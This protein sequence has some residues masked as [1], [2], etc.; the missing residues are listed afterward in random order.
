MMVEDLSYEKVKLDAIL[1][2]K[3]DRLMQ[4]ILTCAVRD[5][6]VVLSI[7]VD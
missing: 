7:P 4:K 3:I 6:L 2:S 5:F 1:Q